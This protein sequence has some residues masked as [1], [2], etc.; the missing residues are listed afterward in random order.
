MVQ[1]T[2]NDCKYT[3]YFC[4][5]TCKSTRNSWIDHW[6]KALTAMN[7]NFAAIIMH[8]EGLASG[9]REDINAQDVA[10][11]QGYL[12]KMKTHKF[13]MYSAIYRDIM[14]QLSI[15]PL[16]FQSDNMTI[17]EVHIDVDIS[18]RNIATLNKEDPED[19]SHL[20][21]FYEEVKL[22]SKR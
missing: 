17:N 5:K 9:E 18:P 21:A 4:S 11:I 19:G 15:L 1:R 10:K 14:K 8:L 13:V 6:R 3:G 22:G 2:T 16:C 12:K 20:K 7:Q